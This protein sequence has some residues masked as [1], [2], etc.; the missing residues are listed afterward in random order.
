VQILGRGAAGAKLTI[1][2]R[3]VSGAVP[4][5]S[6]VD[7]TGQ[8]VKLP[9]GTPSAPRPISA[10]VGVDGTFVANLSLPPGAWDVSVAAPGGGAPLVRRVTVRSAA[11]LSGTLVMRWGTVVYRDRPGW[12]PQSG[13]VGRHQPARAADRHRGEERAAHPPRATPGPSM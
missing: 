5:F 7:S 10:V 13:C 6:I 11:G 2:A 1:S 3:P 4:T 12:Y 9:A 8:P